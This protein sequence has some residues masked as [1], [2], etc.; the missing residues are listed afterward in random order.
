MVGSQAQIVGDSQV[1][2]AEGSQVQMAA[3][4]QIQGEDRQTVDH[5]Y[6]ASLELAGRERF[7]SLG[8]SRQCQ[9]QRCHIVHTLS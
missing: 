1:P 6:Q 5:S 2:T 4:S 9:G 7:H 8:R 3:G